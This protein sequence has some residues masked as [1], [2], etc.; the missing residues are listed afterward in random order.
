M[1]RKRHRH[2]TEEDE[3]T[4]GDALDRKKNP[5]TFGEWHYFVTGLAAGF[6][7]GIAVGP[8]LIYIL[9]KALGG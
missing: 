3:I 7:I 4:L 2:V 5:F 9:I 6:L 1:S 8:I